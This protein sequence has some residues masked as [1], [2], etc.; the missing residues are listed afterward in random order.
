[1]PKPAANRLDGWKAIGDHFGRDPRTV[2]RWRDERGMPVHRVP[3]SRGGSVFAYRG[4]LDEWLNS[5]PEA[6]HP[7]PALGLL[8]LHP[9]PHT[10]SSERPSALRL[11][12]AA[13]V[14]VLVFII[15][16]SVFMFVRTAPTRSGPV[17]TKFEL[18]GTTL[19]ASDGAGTALWSVDL[20]YDPEAPRSQALRA[21]LFDAFPVDLDGDGKS[22]VVAVVAY[23][24]V[25]RTGGHAMSEI[26][27]FDTAGRRLWSYRP[28]VKLLFGSAEFAAPWVPGA[29]ARVSGPKGARVWVS[30]HQRNWWPTF[31]VSLDAEGG[32]TVQ[33]VNA[34]TIVAL[35]TVSRPDGSLVLAGGVNNEWGGAALAV[36]DADGGAAHSPQTAGT[37]YAC[38]GNCPDGS[39]LRYLVFPKTDVYLAAGI[40]FVPVTLIDGPQENG[41]VEVSVRH[42]GQ[43]RAVYRLAGDMYPQSVG[44]SDAYWI[45]HRRLSQEGKIDHAADVCPELTG[46][47]VVRMWEPGAGWRDVTVPP[48]FGRPP[49]SESRTSPR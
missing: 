1:M 40:P 45:A 46:G 23:A 48:T 33:F 20:P 41:I 24:D 28:D 34:G 16:G 19:T 17:P 49:P 15:G 8:E 13:V 25:G 3:G 31:L 2:Q 32:D 39:P 42:E 47:V 44:F 11:R 22:E 12:V 9:A 37:A 10:P 26:H 27:C 7:D 36:L 21:A 38:G 4:E 14:G 5:Q 29:S 6:R 30:F 43:P 35:Q 18:T